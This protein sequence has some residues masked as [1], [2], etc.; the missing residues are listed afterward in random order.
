MSRL[1]ASKSKK[2]VYYQVPVCILVMGTKTRNLKKLEMI[3]LIV[4]VAISHVCDKDELS[5]S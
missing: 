4:R 2:L 3:S 5:M 1:Q